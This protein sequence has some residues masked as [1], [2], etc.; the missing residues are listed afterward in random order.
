MSKALSKNITIGYFDLS[1]K[2][3]ITSVTIN[4]NFLNLL[5]KYVNVKII[6]L[7]KPGDIVREFSNID[8][9]GFDY[10]FIDCFNFLLPSF[11]L[12]E[13]FGLDIPFIC[14][15]HT[16][17][18]WSSRY[19]CIIPLIKK[20]DVVF[21]PSEHAGR[22]FLMISDK[23][24]VHLMPH[25]LDVNRIETLSSDIRRARKGHN[26]KTIAFLGRIRQEKGIGSLIECM[27]E[28]VKRV[29]KSRLDIIGPLSSDCMTDA[30]R[31]TYVKY[32]E[33]KV[34]HMGLGDR[35]RFLGMR[36][37]DDKY[38]ALASSDL[39]V[40]LTVAK[41]ETFPMVNVEALACGLP[42]IAT[43]WA[44]NKEIVRSGEN[45]YLVGVGEGRRS[46]READIKEAVFFITKVLN[47]DMLRVRLGKGAA[48]SA[49]M[50]DYRKVLPAFIRIL[51]M[52]RAKKRR[53]RWDLIKNKR[54]ADFK[55]IFTKDA[56]FFINLGPQ[57]RKKTYGLLYKDMIKNF[58]PDRPPRKM[59]AE[60]T[61]G[62]EASKSI[63]RSIRKAYERYL[64]LQPS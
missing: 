49:R 45:G 3:F 61:G 43:D 24:V 10:L 55:D 37:G 8:R 51:R 19:I 27:P 6:P 56:F 20:Q 7:A 29:K 34:K 38:R 2:K 12:R 59:Q 42:I 31:S 60:K 33:R 58:S 28:I 62:R 35:V 47:D 16:T 1:G 25:M 57:F 52:G 4:E 14:G 15:I 53:S 18:P 64:M 9:Y 26:Y 54:P 23:P 13:K 5:S 63:T 36:M 17:I 11:L 30:P 41:G 44:G 46:S 50:Y 21:S 32:L 39:F 40:N 22:S 48:R